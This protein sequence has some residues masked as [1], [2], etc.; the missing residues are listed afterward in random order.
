MH[1]R[2]QPDCL[3]VNCRIGSLEIEWLYEQDNADVNCRIGS[4]EI[5]KNIGDKIETVNCRIGSLER[6]GFVY[7]ICHFRGGFS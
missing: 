2:K 7:L 4:L 1:R 3:F 5:L 6:F